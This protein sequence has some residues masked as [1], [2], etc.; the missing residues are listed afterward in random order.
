MAGI[1]RTRIGATA[2]VLERATPRAGVAWTDTA[3][4]ALLLGAIAS[5]IARAPRRGTRW[6]WVITIA[7]GAGLLW[8]A[9][10]EQLQDHDPNVRRWKGVQASC[11]VCLDVP[12][13]RQRWP[14]SCV[15][16]D[17]ISRPG[18]DAADQSSRRPSL[19]NGA[20]INVPTDTPTTAKTA[21]S[22]AGVPLPEP[23]PAVFNRPKPPGTST[24][25]AG[26]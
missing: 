18:S 17:E 4:L 9:I 14:V 1:P 15:L 11:S 5:L 6:F 23:M 13:C 25:N 16:E 26:R 7:L 24:Q 2:Y 8:Y 3:E 22:I 21:V 20:P 12:S 10:S 19:L